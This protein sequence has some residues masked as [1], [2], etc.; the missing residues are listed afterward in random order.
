MWTEICCRCTT[1]I[2]ENAFTRFVAFFVFS[3][4]KERPVPP[5]KSRFMNALHSFECGII[6]GIW[7][8]V[9]FATRYNFGLPI[10]LADHQLQMAFDT[11]ITF[12]RQTTNYLRR[13]FSSSIITESSSMKLFQSCRTR[14]TATH[15]FNHVNH[16]KRYKIAPLKI[17]GYFSYANRNPFDARFFLFHWNDFDIK[18]EWKMILFL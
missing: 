16:L 13:F 14:N 3:Q 1:I 11:F 8:F 15:S 5:M 17:G 12:T 10:R 18:N 2:M 9:L 7:H 4:N 6:I